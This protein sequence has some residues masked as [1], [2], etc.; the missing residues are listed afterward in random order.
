[1]LDIR[2]AIREDSWPWL[3][4]SWPVLDAAQPSDPAE[5]IDTHPD[6]R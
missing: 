5:L 3:G 1:M 2:R 4:Q 6:E